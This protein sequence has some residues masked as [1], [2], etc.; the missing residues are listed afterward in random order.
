MGWCFWIDRGGTFTDLI[1][2]DSEG[3]LH[4]RKVLSEQAGAGDPAVSAMKEMLASASPPVDLGD[5]DDVRLGTTVATNALLEGAG[6][7]LLL[8][9]N[10]GLRDQLWIGDQHRDDLFALE[11]PQRPFLAQTVLELTG[12]L[13]ARGEEVEPLVLDQPLRRRLEELRRSGL[14]VAVVALLHAQRNPS[15]EQRCAALLREL[16][17]RTVVCSHQVS[18]MPRLVPRGQTALV[19]GAVHPVL[20]GYLQQ[21]QGALGAAT[22][23]RVMTS[24]GALQAPDRLQA[25]DTILSGPAAGMVGAIAAARMAGFDGVPVL[26]FDMGGTSTD[27]F[28]VA[29]ADVQALRQVKEQTEIAGLQL[30]APRLPIETVAAGGGSVLELE[31]ERLRVGPRS[32]GAQPGPACYRAGGPLTITDANLLLGRLQVDRFPAV[33]GPSGDLPPDV[34]VVRH[35]FAELAAALGQTPERVASGALQLAVE[36]M[37]A[38]IRRVSLHRGEDIRGGVLV[39][40]GGAG[41]QHACRL[42]DELGLNTVLLHPMAGVLSA[43]GMGQARQ[44]CRRQVHLG[45]A[46]SP[47]L[48]AALPDQVKRLMGEAQETLR[49]QGDRADAE[50]GEPEVWVSLALRYPS[51]EQTLVL[52]WF[53]EQ[54]VDAVISAFQASHQQR[55]GYCIDADQA[56]IVEQLNVEVTAPQQFD[57][58]TAAKATAAAEKAEPTP[59]MQPSLQVSMHLELSGWTQVPLLNRS[60]LRLNQRIAGPALIAEATGCTVLEPGWQARVA[61]GGTLLLERSHPAEGSPELAQA[62]THDP[63]QAELFRHRFMAIAEQM[64]EQLRQSSRSVNIRERLDFSCAL[65]DATGGL[66]ANAPHIPVHLGSMGDS[67]RDLLAQVATG[68]VAPLQPGDTLLSNDPFHGGTHLP[69][70]TAISPVFCNGDQPSFFVASRGHH[71]DVGGIAP[72]SMPSFSRTIA[73]EGLLLR[74]QLFV[75]QGRVLAADLEAV[76]SGMATPPR[77]PPELLADLQAQVAAN[78]AGIVALQSLVEREGQTLVQRQMTLLQQDAACNVQ[79]LLLRLTDARHQLALDDGSCLVVQVCLDPNRQRLSLDFSG[80]SPQRPGNFNAPLAVTRAAVLYVIR[81]LLD[82][83][84]PLNE[85]CFAPLDLVV[86]EGCLLNPRPPAAVVAGNVEVSQALCNLLF[87]AFGVQAAGQGT[88][89]NVSFGNGR[90]QYYET[91]AGGGGAGE[92]FAGSVGLQSHMTN[93]RLTDPEVLESRYPVRLESFAVRSGSG[94]QGRWPGGDGLERTIRFLEPMSVSLI[95]GS[96]QV[97]PFGLKGGASGACGENLRLDREGVAHPLPGAVQLELQAGEAIRMLT[98]GGGGMGR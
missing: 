78:Q 44:R 54:G 12:R 26:G 30:L 95:S 63:L 65:F 42:A 73:D 28:C 70:I 19:E 6:A 22:P 38:A 16:S 57:A 43:F 3:Q 25:K 11:Q 9:T 1:G 27:V 36:T 39:A 71:A 76:W 23:L 87:A 82:S 10:A 58:T 94:G 64:G 5:V 55:Y 4:V 35:R 62:G 96:R 46:L 97:A 89:N 8:L 21:V 52:T 61:E 85:G 47:E 75:C 13:D 68:D 60:A 51:A 83:D 33:F 49:R 18:V 15:H 2:R 31:G 93:S 48:L 91:V 86:P 41:G 50:E 98:P 20:D 90:C 80:T 37:A 84:I 79:R 77:N 17:F 14:D 81:C 40:Y 7:P 29:C 24:S 32:A 53:D 45:A 88:M 67:V 92:G 59:E 34:E 56:L 74:N 72:G 66:V 69:D